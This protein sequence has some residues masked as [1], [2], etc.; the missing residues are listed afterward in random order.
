ML[1]TS[2]S[3]GFRALVIFFGILLVV[4]TTG[5]GNAIQGSQR[6]LY[7]TLFALPPTLPGGVAASVVVFNTGNEDAQIR[8]EPVFPLAGEEMRAAMTAGQSRVLAD[9]GWIDAGRP[10]RLESSSARVEVHLLLR[11]LSGELIEAF[12]INHKAA[13]RQDF[14]LP[15]ASENAAC[16]GATPGGAAARTTLFVVPASARASNLQLRAISAQGNEVATAKVGAFLGATAGIA[17]AELFSPEALAATSTVRVEST[18]PFSGYGF[19]EVGPEDVLGLLPMNA[20]PTWVTEPPQ[21]WNPAEV[22]AEVVVYNPQSVAVEVKMGGNVIKLAAGATR[23]LAWPGAYTWVRTELPIALFV[24]Y[25]QYEGCGVSAQGACWDD[26][27]WSLPRLL[28]RD[29]VVVAFGPRLP[30]N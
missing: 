5:T 23:R 27:P 19:A 13:R 8:L 25:S 16:P 1:A 12:P 17:L 29:D 7:Q 3:E 6:N 30:P 24:A 26:R 21:D 2:R 4:L 14:V 10:I 18:Q 20:S 28:V 9:I 15:I 11:D 22:R